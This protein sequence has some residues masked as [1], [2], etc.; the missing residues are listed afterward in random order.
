MIDFGSAAH[1]GY[2]SITDTYDPL[3]NRRACHDASH[4]L[5]PAMLETPHGL[6]RAWR[7]SAT[8]RA[9]ACSAGSR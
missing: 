8:C 7:I 1:G 4:L 3:S 6:P 2:F 5:P 9:A